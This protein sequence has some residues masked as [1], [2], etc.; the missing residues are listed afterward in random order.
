MW[1]N[2][3]WQCLDHL[4]RL[5]LL[6]PSLLHLVIFLH[7]I[8]TEI[9]AIWWGETNLSHLFLPACPTSEDS[10][11]WYKDTAHHREE[12]VRSVLVFF[13]FDGIRPRTTCETGSH[14]KPSFFY[15]LPFIVHLCFS[16]LRLSFPLGRGTTRASRFDWH[17]WET[18]V[19]VAWMLIA[20]ISLGSIA[21]FST[22]PRISRIPRWP[23]S[24][25]S[26]TFLLS[27]PAAFDVST[28]QTK[29]APTPDELSEI[30]LESVNSID[31]FLAKQL[32][33]LPSGASTSTNTPQMP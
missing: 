10:V 11:Q 26:S 27:F 25:C 32:A 20:L 13:C 6:T 19:D 12:S 18:K 15:H 16:A 21:N 8:R 4:P 17:T 31:S 30:Q 3:A 29:P 1:K 28:E 5:M 33:R 24:S 2:K 22:C 14:W 23:S 9:P 7:S